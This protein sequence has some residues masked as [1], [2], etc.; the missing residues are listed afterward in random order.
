MPEKKVYSLKGIAIGVLGFIILIIGFFVVKT[1]EIPAG[2]VGVIVD[3]PYFFGNQG[4]RD[5]VVQPGRKWLWVTTEVVLIDSTPILKK[6]V[7][8]DYMSSDGVPLDFEAVI[9]VQITDAANMIAQFGPNWY[10]NNIQKEFQNAIRDTVKKYG[11]QETAINASASAKIDAEVTDKMEKYIKSAKIPVRLIQITLGKANPPDSVKDQ[12]IATAQQEQRVQTEKQRKL[13]EDSRLAAEASRAAAD[14][15]YRNEMSLS[16][17]Q[18]ISLE[19]LKTY[20]KICGVTPEGKS[21]CTFF[22]GGNPQPVV[23]AGK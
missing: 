17:Q 6:E 19:T 9:R 11:L 2:K 4:V 23:N 10:E 20:E 3:K 1:V 16:P 22:I 13:A 7:A 12:R 5:D 8:N 15:K 14:N 18:F 21:N